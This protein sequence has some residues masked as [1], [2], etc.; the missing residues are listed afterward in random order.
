M[1]SIILKIFCK[2]IKTGCKMD[3]KPYLL[4]K[5]SIRKIQETR[6]STPINSENE[7]WLSCAK[8]R[9]RRILDEVAIEILFC[10]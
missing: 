7:S 1:I 6:L 4:L 9:Y 8:D 3:R 5:V 2:N 10:F